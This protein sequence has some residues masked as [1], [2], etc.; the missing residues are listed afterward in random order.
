MK[1]VTQAQAATC[2]CDISCSHPGQQVPLLFF[3]T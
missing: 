1:A 3:L 2:Q